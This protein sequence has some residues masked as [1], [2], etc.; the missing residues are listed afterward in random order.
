MVGER[1]RRR[2]TRAE[3]CDKSIIT[4]EN[5]GWTEEEEE[6]EEEEEFPISYKKQKQ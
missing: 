2:P 6:E 5:H 1:R 3:D 4:L